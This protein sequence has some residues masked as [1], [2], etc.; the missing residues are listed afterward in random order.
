MFRERNTIE[1][2]LYAQ[3]YDKDS[4]KE[5]KWFAKEKLFQHVV[6]TPTCGT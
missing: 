2:L 1:T 6:Q 5:Y 4:L 3:T